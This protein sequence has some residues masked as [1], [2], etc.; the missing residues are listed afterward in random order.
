[1]NNPKGIAQRDHYTIKQLFYALIYSGVSMTIAG[2]SFPASGGEHLISHTL[3][4]T[5]GL[6]GIPHD[7][8]GRQVGVG[9]IFASA[10]YERILQNSSPDF[11][12]PDDAA[13]RN[14][15]KSLSPVVEEQNILKYKKSRAA[16]G[17]L[18]EPGIW[19][20]IVIQLAAETVPAQKIK[21]CLASAQAAHCISHIGCSR[22]RFKQAV[23]HSHQMRER[24][25]VIDLARNT[26]ILPGAVDDIIDQYLIK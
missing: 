16:A 17:K 26:G 23:L 9:T 11:I 3:D 22:E 6:S 1:M 24:Y 19:K 13:D 20:E 21:N 7:Y 18:K 10:L 4:M 25:T 15:W 14:Y 5:A 8:H 2:T 12:V